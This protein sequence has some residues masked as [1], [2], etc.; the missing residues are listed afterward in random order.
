MNFLS[1]KLS[2][3]GKDSEEYRVTFK[4]LFLA[5]TT[6]EPGTKYKLIFK[7]GNKRNETQERESRQPKYGGSLSLIDFSDQEPY[8]DC[9]G[10]FKDKDGSFLVKKAKC[11][12]VY[13]L[14]SN[15]GAQVKICSE[16][17]EISK[18]VGLGVVK[19]QIQLKNGASYADF[20]IHVDK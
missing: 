16:E 14:P 13:F 18:Y 1:K 12:V 20:L 7:R 6:F 3:M 9:S 17:F 19:D 15:P 2:R 4:P 8:S 10:F 5:V 11:K